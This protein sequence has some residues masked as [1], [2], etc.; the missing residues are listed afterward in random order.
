MKH[1]RSLSWPWYLA[2]FVAYFACGNLLS[3]LS[4]QSQIVPIWLPAGI[5]LVACYIWWWRFFPAV[6]LASFLFNL[7]THNLANF[8]QLPANVFYEAAL[9][10]SGATLQAIVG[11]WLLK[12][13]LGNPLT[14]YSEKRILGFIFIVGVLVNLIAANIGVFALSQYSE[15]YNPQNYLNNMFTWWMGD[16]LGVLVG[17]PLILSLIKFTSSD[18][19]A[20]KSRMFIIVISCVLLVSVYLTTLMFSNYSYKNGIEIAKKEVQVINNAIN[21]EISKNQSQLQMLARFLQT[22]PSATRQAFDAFSKNI[23]TKQSSIN[24]LSWNL[25][26][27]QEQVNEFVLQLQDIYQRPISLIGNPIEETD[28]LVVIKYIYPVQGNETAIGFNVNSNPLRKTALFNMQAPFKLM[29]TP[30]INLVQ[31]STPKPAYLLFSSVFEQQQNVS[32]SPEIIGYATGVFLIEEMLQQA[33]LSANPGIFT[34]ELVDKN[35]AEVFAGNTGKTTIS[36]LNEP[37]LFTLSFDI[38]GQIWQMNL[39]PKTAYLIHNQSDLLLLLYIFQIFFVAFSMTLVLLMNS[40]QSVLNHLVG[41]RTNELVLANQA[42]SQFL[43]NMSHELRT[44]LNAVIGFSQLANRS[45]DTNEINKYIGRIGSASKTLLS[46]INEILDFSKSESGKLVLEERPF[47]IHELLQ[48]T[49]SLFEST[50]QSKGI[51]WSIKQNLPD[52]LW[53]LGDSLRLEQIIN[54]LCSNALKFTKQGEVELEVQL[55]KT[56]ASLNLENDVTLKIAVKDSGIGMTP[57][58]QASLFSAFSQA[59]ASTTREYGGTGLGLAISQKLCSLMGSELKVKSTPGQGSEFYF[60]VMLKVCTALPGE[61]EAV[62]SS[63]NTAL[64]S[65]KKILVAEDNEINQIVITEMLKSLGANFVVVENGQLAIDAVNKLS[66][67]IILMDCQMPIVDGFEATKIIRQKKSISEL[68]IVAL[69]ADVMPESRELAEKLGF[70]GYLSKPVTIEI[71]I[72]CLLQQLKI[73]Q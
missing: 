58:Q 2:A 69:T 67:D 17:T 7:S 72:E 24:A 27:E 38:A 4:Q 63:I 18:A 20:Q 56:P 15:S 64:L 46:L 48:R 25:V 52:P 26:L 1:L 49:N 39:V 43:A 40:R 35:A 32:K 50:S 51:N 13:F 9:I 37:D 5:A 30:V 21:G 47:S 54:N 22:N 16:S 42:K 73:E 62:S 10:A 33:F 60:T 31:A 14:L 66:F 68:P 41:E 12:Y 45:T 19:N 29:A 70:T 11:S 34:Y 57:H 44:P 71:L 8:T 6:F 23:V 53:L 59:D 28:P 3:S 36:L 61:S 65:K 55:V